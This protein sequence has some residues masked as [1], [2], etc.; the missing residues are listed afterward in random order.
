M[1]TDR[2]VLEEGARRRRRESPDLSSRGGAR[3]ENTANGV[4]GP[5]STRIWVL[6]HERGTGKAQVG[7]DRR[8]G[9]RRGFLDGEGER[10]R[11]GVALACGPGSAA[12][13]ASARREVA[14]GPA[15]G[16]S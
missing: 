1:A 15:L 5:D 7:L 14:A 11:A 9:A 3:P 4:P 13:E 8:C 2:V 16:L 12:A 10:R 6:E